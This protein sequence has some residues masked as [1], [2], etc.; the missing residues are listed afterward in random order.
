MA[1]AG[2]EPR[3]LAPTHRFADPLRR[4]LF[5]GRQERHRSPVVDTPQGAGGFPKRQRPAM[6]I[7]MDGT[8]A[9]PLSQIPDLL[10]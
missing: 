5:A 1:S 8:R 10:G 7:A 3:V 9:R 2:Q 4:D 6:Y